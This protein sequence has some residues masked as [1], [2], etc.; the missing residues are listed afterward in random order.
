MERRITPE[1][2]IGPRLA[3]TRWANPP[4]ALLCADKQLMHPATA[5]PTDHLISA[6]SNLRGFNWS[7][8]LW[9]NGLGPQRMRSNNDGTCH[10]LVMNEKRDVALK[11]QDLKV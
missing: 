6:P 5:S 9:K 11:A 3:R 2:V 1:P 7:A 8:L 4:Y 10:L